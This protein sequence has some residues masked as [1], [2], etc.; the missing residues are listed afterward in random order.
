MKK[1]SKRIASIIAVLCLVMAAFPVS[2]FAVTGGEE[3]ATASTTVT[4]TS[5]ASYTIEIPSSITFPAGDTTAMI[6]ITCSANTLPYGTTVVVSLDAN[7]T[8]NE[9]GNFYL[10]NTSD[11]SKV[12]KCDIYS[13]SGRLTRARTE[14][15]KYNSGDASYPEHDLEVRIA[16]SSPGPGTYTGT[17]YFSI[18]VNHN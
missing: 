7:S 9:D 18:G 12:I 15:V 14:V 2:A 17:I 6:T 5:S 4:Y 8:F 13:D 10:V 11:D 3:G 16:S 1:N